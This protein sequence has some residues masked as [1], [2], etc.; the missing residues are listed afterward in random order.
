[1]KII[2]WIK[3]RFEPPPPRKM[4]AVLNVLTTQTWDETGDMGTI[5]QAFYLYDNGVKR[6]FDTGGFNGFFDGG[7]YKSHPCY[8][9]FVRPWLDGF[10]TNKDME[11]LQAA[12]N[13]SK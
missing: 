3:K 1:M 6:S 13:K 11:A 5:K 2:E 12:Y 4:V 9:R 7:D 10:Y 8:V